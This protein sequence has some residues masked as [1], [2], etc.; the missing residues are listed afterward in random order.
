MPGLELI[1]GR[2]G[3]SGRC[4][5]LDADDFRRC[6]GEVRDIFRYIPSNTKT[7]VDLVVIPFGSSGTKEVWRMSRP[8][9][10]EQKAET[11]AKLPSFQNYQRESP[12]DPH[13]S[14]CWMEYI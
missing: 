6:I 1:L 7:N 5:S 11:C 3:S 2:K 13:W 14:S 4:D 12:Q 8:F 10:R 9:A